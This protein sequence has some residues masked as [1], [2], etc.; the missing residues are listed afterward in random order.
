VSIHWVGRCSSD[1]G[2][3]KMEIKGEVRSG[4]TLTRMSIALTETRTGP[5]DRRQVG[6][7]RPVP[8]RA[9][10][11]PPSSLRVEKQIYLLLPVRL[12]GGPVPP[13]PRRLITRLPVTSSISHR[14]LRPHPVTHHRR[15]QSIRHR[16]AHSISSLP[17]DW[18]VQVKVKTDTP[19]V[20]VRMRI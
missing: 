7:D 9:A 1:G 19:R 3:Q 6:L 20:R 11:P 8:V 4:L 17:R 15:S 10:R 2:A 13:P 16:G 12:P 5:Q 18:A 14:P